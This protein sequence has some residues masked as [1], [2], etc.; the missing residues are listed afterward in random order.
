M[1]LLPCQVIR[2][3]RQTTLRIIG[4]QPATDRRL[5]S[6]WRTIERTGFGSSAATLP[7]RPFAALPCA[8][9]GPLYLIAE[10]SGERS[11]KFASHMPFAH[12]RRTM[13]TNT[14]S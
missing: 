3:A 7:L 9:T 4:W 6:A 10:I 2:R 14:P 1:I 11:R 5:F 12:A 8:S 13:T